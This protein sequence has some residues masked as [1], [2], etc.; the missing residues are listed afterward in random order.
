MEAYSGKRTE[1]TVELALEGDAVAVE[2][3]TLIANRGTWEGTATE[4]LGALLEY[5]PETTQNKEKCTFGKISVDT[6]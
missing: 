1:A 5:V 2:V 4:L 6:R 3:Q